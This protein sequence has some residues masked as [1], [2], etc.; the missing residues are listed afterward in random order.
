MTTLEWACRLADEG[1]PFC[2]GIVV[3][4]SGSSPQG[5]GAKS[6]FLPDGR[7]I[8]TLGGGCLEM[9][10]RR[11]A[12]DALRSE[13]TVYREFKLDDDFGWDDGLICG[14][15]VRVFL[16]PQ[17]T[18]F[19]DAVRASLA[20]SPGALAWGL[21]GSV[22]GEA[23]WGGS[24]PPQEAVAKALETGRE[25]LTEGEDAWFLEPVLPPCRLILF[26]A[27]HISATLCELAARA[28][29]DVTVVDDRAAYANSE[30]LPAA[31]A[32]VVE[33]PEIAAR[34]LVIDRATY[35]CLITR[36]HRNDAKVLREVIHAPAA[37]IGMIGSRRKVE[38]VR[39]QFL[40]EGLCTAEEFERVKS[41]MGLDIGAESVFEIA[42]S[43]VAELLRV[44]ASR[45]GPILA[46]CGPTPLV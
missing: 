26:G 25:V 8:G 5:P 22:A 13:E 44:R 14:G 18:K 4:K 41:P 7:V 27:G 15:R 11:L 31:G 6:L 40:E 12:L 16:N 23:V 37:Y 35:L 36:G 19:M 39:K 24:G 3:A 45:R 38:T 33:Q 42:V 28:G 43:I 32:I 1:A 17:P 34:N 2:V 29:F 10:A 9:E 21:S 46:R 20:G 30:R